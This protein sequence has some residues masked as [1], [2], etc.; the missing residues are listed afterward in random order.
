MENIEDRAKGL[1]NSDL[2]IMFR[3]ELIVWINIKPFIQPD[4]GDSFLG[5]V[6][7]FL[8]KNDGFEILQ[9]C[10]DASENGFQ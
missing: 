3:I 7:H 1:L 5:L 4:L 9:Q 6:D 2:S 8:G 10:K